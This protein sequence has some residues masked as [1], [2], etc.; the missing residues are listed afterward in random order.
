MT[1]LAGLYVPVRVY[2]KNGNRGQQMSWRQSIRSE[3]WL[4]LRNWRDT[5]MQTVAEARTTPAGA[6]LDSLGPLVNPDAARIGVALPPGNYACRWYELGGAAQ[7]REFTAQPCIFGSGQ[8]QAVSISVRQQRFV[9]QLFPD[10]ARRSVFL[11]A[12]ML[13]DEQTPLRYG[14]DSLRDVVGLTERIGKNHWRLLIPD[15]P[16]AE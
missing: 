5:L 4:A 14:R 2:A 8:S 1:S 11:G 15:P 7:F 12:V 10:N 13:G 3:D 16:F 9:G 6:A